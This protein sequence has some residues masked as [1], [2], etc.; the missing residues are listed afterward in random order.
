MSI[1]AHV[2][3]SYLPVVLYLTVMTVAAVG[4]GRVPVWAHPALVIPGLAVRALTATDWAEMAFAVG[5]GVV[6]FL[7]GVFFLGRVVSGGTLFTLVGAFTLAPVSWA[8]PGILAGLMTVGVYSG[9]R[10]ARSL[11]GQHVH[12]TA[13]QVAFAFGVSPGG[14]TLPDPETI[15]GKRPVP[16]AAAPGGEAGQLGGSSALSI[17]PF[18]LVGVLVAGTLHLLLV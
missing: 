18:L 1:P 8:Y 9:W 3:V 6:L 11:G 10:T 4:L 16:D 14:I 2:L 13:W 5:A 17:Q 12:R 15:P 7:G